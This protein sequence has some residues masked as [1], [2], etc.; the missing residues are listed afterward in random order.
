MK[1][2]H[3]LV[4]LSRSKFIPSKEKPYQTDK[5]RGK[6]NVT[7]GI[8]DRR[9]A[10]HAK[11]DHQNNSRNFLNAQARGKVDSGNGQ[12]D[13]LE[14]GHDQ[15]QCVP[16]GDLSTLSTE[17]SDS[18]VKSR[19]V[20]SINEAEV[21]MP[22][23]E[24]SQSTILK[25]VRE[26]STNINIARM[27]IESEDTLCCQTDSKPNDSE[28]VANISEARIQMVPPNP[29]E[30]NSALVPST[31]SDA[32][33]TNSSSSETSL[34]TTSVDE[35]GK[36]SHA[37]SEARLHMVSPNTIELNSAV[38]LSTRSDAQTLN[39]SS[40]EALLSATG[41]DETG[42]E[43][44]AVGFYNGEVR[45]VYFVG[46]P[47]EHD[48]SSK[49]QTIYVVNESL[50]PLCFKIQTEYCPLTYIHYFTRKVWQQTNGRQLTDT[51][52]LTRRVS[53]KNVQVVNDQELTSRFPNR[54]TF[55]ITTQPNN[56]VFSI[57]SGLL[58]SCGTC[59][60]G[61]MGKPN[62]MSHLKKESHQIFCPSNI[63]PSVWGKEKSKLP[64]KQ[65]G[66]PDYESKRTPFIVSSN[67]NFL[68]ST[69]VS[70]QFKYAKINGRKSKN[71]G[72]DSNVRNVKKRAV[73]ED[74]TMEV[75]DCQSM[76]ASHPSQDTLGQDTPQR[77]VVENSLCGSK[78]TVNCYIC[79]ADIDEF[80]V[81]EHLNVVHGLRMGDTTSTSYFKKKFSGCSN[82][83]L[84]SFN[85][86]QM[87]KSPVDLLSSR[88]SLEETHS[89]AISQPLQLN[90]ET[91]V[92]DLTTGM[93]DNNNEGM[94][95]TRKSSRLKEKPVHSY[96]L[97]DSDESMVDDSDDDAT[98]D[99]P[100]ME[101]EST[102]DIDDE[103]VS[104]NVEFK[105]G[106]G[107]E[108]EISSKILTSFPESDTEDD[109]NSEIEVIR[110]QN[111]A[112]RRKNMLETFSK[113]RKCLT[114]EPDEEDLKL[115]KRFLVR[116]IQI[117]SHKYS[118]YQKKIPTLYRSQMSKGEILKG[119]QAK[120]QPATV[121]DC[122]NGMRRLMISI[123]EEQNRLY[124]GKLPNGQMKYRLEFLYYIILY[125]SFDIFS[126]LVTLFYAD[127]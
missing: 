7:P 109:V 75:Y 97:H 23:F 82:N 95:Q 99:V 61:T 103:D 115:E 8:L 20:L 85:S 29:I 14:D 125:K 78:N 3:R 44:H 104:V 126:C 84:S 9:K 121:N 71:V 120:F 12:V 2:G 77:F 22:L 45:N 88:S 98:Y 34:S 70:D 13:L 102:S 52:V 86:D 118:T 26:M 96:K 111:K 94:E 67:L 58:W 123:Q 42:R 80:S 64:F 25:D 110:K 4:E 124:P 63:P 38:V 83:D 40:P 32:Q 72:I 54:H 37:S 62:M 36:E 112:E 122:K 87:N 10:Y 50:P 43:N 108:S 27:H 41:V 16:Q 119:A 18:I 106:Q 51:S 49:T 66:E 81:D 65:W 31:G 6:E 53:A 48:F 28:S 30:I 69:E 21:E 68:D 101:L 117:N 114:F 107:K 15:V 89:K 60:K 39:T 57:H 55:I 92:M 76:S 90:V 91:P 11:L 127:P 35:N 116:P 113:D 24:S 46:H 19:H 59:V 79:D 74:V 100:V 47:R 5:S 1:R 56:P 93:S 105:N 17:E 33:T 73:C